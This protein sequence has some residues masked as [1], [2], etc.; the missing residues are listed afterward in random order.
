MDL[1]DFYMCVHFVCGDLRGHT[2][3]AVC[4]SFQLAKDC[5]FKVY[6]MSLECS[7]TF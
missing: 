7:D 5:G 6:M 1:C 3:A 2:V 4:N